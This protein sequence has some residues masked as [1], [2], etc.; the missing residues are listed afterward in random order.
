MASVSS[1]DILKQFAELAKK[2]GKVARNDGDADKAI[3]GAAATYERV[4]ELPYLAHATMEP[5]NCTAEVTADRCDVWAPTQSQTSTQQAAMAASGLPE[6]K[7]FV[8][9]T[10][11]G[12]GFGRRGETDF[13]TDAVETSKAVGKPVKV[14][15]S[16]EDDM[17]HDYYR[18][19]TYIRLQAAFDANNNPSPGRSTSSSRRCSSV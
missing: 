5:M 15:W 4:F 2:T 19:I 13:V 7:V 10:Y 11:L 1:D 9:T 18:P 8:H 12:G 14:I 16:R 3:A 6:A 17:H